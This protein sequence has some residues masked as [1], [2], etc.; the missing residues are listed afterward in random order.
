MDSKDIL[1]TV[2]NPRERVLSGFAFTTLQEMSQLYELN[3]FSL[4]CQ[5]FHLLS[6]KRYLLKLIRSPKNLQVSF[7]SFTEV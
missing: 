7:S 3:M 5:F 1:F 6:T 4:A 2:E